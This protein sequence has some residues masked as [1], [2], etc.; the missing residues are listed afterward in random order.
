MRKIEIFGT[1]CSKCKRLVKNVEK[2]VEEL[3]IDA[4]IV[5]VESLEEISA[6]GVMATPGL[7]IDGETIATGKILNSEQIKGLLQ[8]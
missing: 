7:V 1:G 4:E 3:G 2:A 5:K 8:D 6:R